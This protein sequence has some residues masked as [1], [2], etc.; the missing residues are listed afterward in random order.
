MTTIEKIESIEERFKN[1]CGIDAN[2]SQYPIKN[3]IQFK[4]DKE[5]S[6]NFAEVFTPLHIVDQ[7]INI[8]PSVDI[9]T[10][11]VD[12][13]AGF[14]QF[15][16][17]EIRYRFEQFDEFFNVDEFLKNKHLFSELQISSCCKLL[18]I[19]GIKI[20]LAI[21]DALQLAKLP[22]EA[23]GIW[24][25]VEKLGEWVNA[26][27][28]VKAIFAEAFDDKKKK[29]E[30]SDG[31]ESVFV[32]IIN[33]VIINLNNICEGESVLESCFVQS[34]KT[35]K[36]REEAIRLITENE[37]VLK[38]NWQETATPEWLVREMINCVE[39]VNSLKKILVIFNIEFLECLIKEKGID[40]SV[41][42]FAFDNELEGKFAKKV[43]GVDGFNIGGCLDTFK[44]A[45]QGIEGK[46]D[47]VLSNPPYQ[48]QSEKQKEIEGNNQ[49]HAKPIYN[50]IVEYSIDFLK[51]K[52]ICMI[53]PSRWMVGGRG[54]DDYRGRLLND[55][56]IKL[57]QDFEGSKEIFSNSNINGGVSYFLW[58]KDY[59]GEC[60][61]NGVYRN[62]NEFDVLVRNNISCQILNKVISKTN[63]FCNKKHLSQNPFG[64]NSNF[65]E[66]VSKDTINSVVCKSSDKELKYVSFFQDRHN[67][68]NLWKVIITHATPG[69]LSDTSTVARK[70]L[71]GFMILDPNQICTQTY[72]VAGV[73]NSKKE[74]ENY[75]GYMKTKFYR[76]MLSLRLITQNIST[77]CFA[78]VPDMGD[79]THEYT[80]NDLYQHYGL[81]RKEID[82]IEKSIK[83]IK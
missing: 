29:V 57:I 18:W 19:F 46:Y 25:Y 38:K 45:T 76:F 4:T 62:L 28:L 69:G 1:V 82:H 10:K 31:R 52:Y 27:T 33:K 12:L 81:T 15:T 20:H 30:Y 24:L 75:M 44:A 47:L 79:Y 68:L 49:K 8:I 26:T 51:P 42:D 11:S 83:E 50:E 34:V 6:R 60:N 3:V 9:N 56:R 77:D 72:L 36:G 55:N 78:W 21:G 70:L 59:N 13:C 17:R 37:T 58:D 64:I 35:K 43:Y 2:I 67:I 71:M 40:P 54:L 66:W 41:V 80:D 7:M 14:G 39:D 5:K 65:S 61:F 16:V 53:T 63:I 22:I 74:A 23:K 32:K 48:I 73:F